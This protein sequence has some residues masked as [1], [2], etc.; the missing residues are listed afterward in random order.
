MNIEKKLIAF[1]ILGILIGVSSVVPLVFLMSATAQVDT[2]DQPWFTITIPY[3]YWM[4]KDGVIE[5]QGS[6]LPDPVDESRM[7]SE[8]HSIIYNYTL[9][10][11]PTIDLSDARIE[12]FTIELASDKGLVQ[13]MPYSLATNSNPSFGREDI[14]FGIEGFHFM[15]DDWFDTSTFNIHRGGGGGLL[16]LNWT[17]G[18]SRLWPGGGAGMGTIGS[19][20]T[21]HLVDALRAAET[22]TMTV[23]RVG[24]VALSGNST[25]VHF[26]NN[27]IVD[28][29]QLQKYHEGWIYNALVSEEE[30]SEIDLLKPISYEDLY[31]P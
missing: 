12:Y 22:L 6:S 29:I 15:R 9:N 3:T 4:T 1:S 30:L 2:S 14:P 25:I 7:V 28:Q 26:A 18:E 24:W 8:Q 27:E 20:G 21:S 31:G 13:T 16:R 11:D 23:Y 5:M 10:V 19:S 17:L